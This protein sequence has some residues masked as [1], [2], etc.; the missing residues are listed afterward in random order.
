MAGGKPAG[1]YLALVGAPHRHDARAFKTLAPGCL[2]STAL[3]STVG[4]RRPVSHAVIFREDSPR[5]DDAHNVAE[6]PVLKEPAA[7]IHGHVE[8]AMR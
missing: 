8:A 1:T 3:V 6:Q 4:A 5:V 2:V 7:I